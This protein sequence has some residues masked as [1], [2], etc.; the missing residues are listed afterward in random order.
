[1]K[2][3][4]STLSDEDFEDLVNQDVRGQLDREIS[5]QLR[6]PENVY[7]WYNSLNSLKKSVEAQFVVKKAE[8]SE[9]RLEN[10]TED[11]WLR[12]VAE[13]ERWKAG[14]VRFKTGVEK[15]IAEAKQLRIAISKDEVMGRI[16]SDLH[17]ARG[18][19]ELYRQAI[20]AHR[21]AEDA[22]QA[23]DQLYSIL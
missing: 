8:L 19:A 7:R 20:L 22:D 23:D 12:T 9:Q 6:E 13:H 2:L 15:R 5:L 3:V 10:P 1:M 11:E 21:S 14:A 18:K 17:E 16:S 4:L